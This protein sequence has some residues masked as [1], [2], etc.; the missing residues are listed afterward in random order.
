MVWASSSGWPSAGNNQN[1]VYRTVSLLV[2]TFGLAAFLGLFVLWVRQQRLER[3]K[4]TGWIYPAIFLASAAWFALNLLTS[5]YLILLAAACAFP[6]LLGKL[7]GVRG[8]PVLAL[9]SA[10]VAAA[11]VPFGAW[12]QELSV[13]YCALL[14]WA[15]LAALLRGPAGPPA[16][17][18]VARRD[19]A[20]P[21]GDVHA[22]GLAQPSHAISPSDT[23][24]RR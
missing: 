14:A 12:R 6:P 16:Y 18:A 24:A 13:A 10:T 15:C 5:D 8:L 17:S 21:S 9:A 4:L 20:G 1:G 2:Y 23:A 11:G 22:I 7:F 3:P 19:A